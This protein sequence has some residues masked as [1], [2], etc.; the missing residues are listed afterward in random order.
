MLRR[1]AVVRHYSIAKFVWYCIPII[2]VQQ[3][4]SICGFLP[5]ITGVLTWS[6][7]RFSTQESLHTL[8]CGPSLFDS[9]VCTVFHPDNQ[10]ST[11]TL[12][13]RI[14]SLQKRCSIMVELAI[15]NT[16]IPCAPSLFDSEV[17]TV[18]RPD[19]QG[20]T[21]PLNLRILSLQNGR[22]IMVEWAILTCGPSL[23][24]SEVC[25]VFRPDNRGSP[26]VRHYSIARFLR[27]FV[28][29]IKVQ[30]CLCSVIIR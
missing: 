30:Q 25:T 8:P 10:G 11:M 20:S 1:Q 9:G 18:F 13:L 21:M 4:L 27:Y 15:F 2:K 23:F 24:D 22:S 28:R 7:K 29:I 6:K 17:S 19:N 26:V 16:K 14:L 12:N 3:C 5:F